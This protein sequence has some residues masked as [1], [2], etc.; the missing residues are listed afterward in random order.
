MKAVVGKDLA[1]VLPGEPILTAA[2]QHH[3]GGPIGRH[4]CP[5]VPF[6]GDECQPV[7]PGKLD[8]LWGAAHDINFDSGIW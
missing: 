8:R 2:V 5:A 7:C 3:D 1:G 6:V 4:A